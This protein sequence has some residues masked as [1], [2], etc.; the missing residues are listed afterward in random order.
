MT[1]ITTLLTCMIQ[2]W[3]LVCV[4]MHCTSWKNN[5][6]EPWLL[7]YYMCA[8]HHQNLCYCA[9]SLLM[10]GCATIEYCL[11]FYKIMCFLHIW[12]GKGNF[13]IV[14][15]EDIC[16][17]FQHKNHIPYRHTCFTPILIILGVLWKKKILRG[18]VRNVKQTKLINSMM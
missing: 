4:L 6:T 5:V 17:L 10:W 3:F 1:L 16:N 13:Y 7:K 18:E 14:M 11:D 9:K 15:F 8:F 12:L 2:W